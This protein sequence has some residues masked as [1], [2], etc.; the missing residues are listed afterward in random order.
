[1]KEYVTNESFRAAMKG[2]T[3]L[4]VTGSRELLQTV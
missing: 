1:M 2:Y 3:D 4:Y